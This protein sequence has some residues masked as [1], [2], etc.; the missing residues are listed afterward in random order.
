MPA[1]DRQLVERARRGD[2]DAFEVLVRRHLDATYAVA[3]G[4]LGEPADAEDV[5]QDALVLALE[6]LDECRQPDRFRGWLLAIARNTALNRL[7]AA[8]VRAAS[9]LESV[10]GLASE[11]RRTNPAAHTEDALLRRRLL[12][13]LD[14]LDP[15]RREVVLLHDLEGWK[16]REIA[17][18]LGLPEGTVRS[19]L[20]LARRS[21]RERLVEEDS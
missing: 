3:L 12:R 14:T 9:P 13:A 5:A 19:H 8:R 11:A 18:A 15:V 17:D 20:S 7:Q 1:T 6:R 16:H 21:L 4:V 2:R 10:G